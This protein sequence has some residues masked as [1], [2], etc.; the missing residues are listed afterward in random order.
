MSTS[1]LNDLPDNVRLIPE[2]E[3][4]F[5]ELDHHQQVLVFKGLRKIA[6]DPVSIGKW[7]GNR[8]SNLRIVWTV[9]KDGRD[10][11]DVAI[12]TGV[13][14]G[15]TVSAM[16]ARRRESAIDFENALLELY[17]KRLVMRT[18]PQADL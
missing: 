2:A 5:L 12:V 3:E 16:V 10:F 7:L 4:E 1:F 14:P 9:P 18:S 8:K 15:E 13:G 6:Q 17:K 11:I